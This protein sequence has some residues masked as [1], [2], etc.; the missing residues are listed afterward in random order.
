MRTLIATLALTASVL[1]AGDEPVSI[2]LPQ[3]FT[4]AGGYI[5]VVCK[6]P[7]NEHNRGLTIGIEGEKNSYWQIDGEASKV[8]FELGVDHMSCDPGPAFCELKMDSGK[9]RRVQQAFRVIGCPNDDSSL[10]EP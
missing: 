6:V 10:G 3:P 2:R 9:T 1:A 4:T 5:R 7:R 8:T